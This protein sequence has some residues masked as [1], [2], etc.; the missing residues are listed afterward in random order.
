MSDLLY[1]NGRQI[2]GTLVY[3]DKAGHRMEMHAAKAFIEMRSQAAK[4][5]VGLT[6]DS[7]YRSMAEQDKLYRLY[8]DGKGNVAARPGFSNHQDG[9][10]VDIDTQKG[11]NAAYKW[12]VVNAGK[13]GF[14]SDVPGEPW[15][16]HWK[17]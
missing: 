11:T 9:T 1:R 6:I 14:I 17:S 15:H 8:K 16:W 2:Q 13:Y 4:D 7:A 12:L 5:G 3:V 10:A